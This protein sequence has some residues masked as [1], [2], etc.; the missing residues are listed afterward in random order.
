MRTRL[1]LT[2][3]VNIFFNTV[4][5]DILFRIDLRTSGQCPVDCCSVLYGIGSYL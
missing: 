3:T 5:N 2:V 1:L 4:K